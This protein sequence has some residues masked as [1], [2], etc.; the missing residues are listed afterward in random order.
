MFQQRQQK[1]VIPNL[2]CYQTGSHC[3]TRPSYEQTP[4][5]KKI[6]VKVICSD[7]PCHDAP[8][9]QKYLIFAMSLQSIK[10]FIQL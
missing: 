5:K 10:R 3:D 4:I 1:P 6:N 8:Q 2:A 9:T 7:N